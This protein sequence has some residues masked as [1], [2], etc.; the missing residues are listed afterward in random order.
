MYIKKTAPLDYARVD[1]R[2]RIASFCILFL[3]GIVAVRLFFLMIIEHD[4]YT[5]IA[6]GSH[7]STAE[8]LPDRGKI[9]IQDSR[10]GETYPA[11]INRDVFL[12]Y[13]DTREIKD[14]AAAEEIAAVFADVFHYDD[15]KKGTVFLQLG[16]RT[17]PYEPIE[18]DVNEATVDS[19]KMHQLS[20]IGFV[21][22]FE[23]FYPEETLAAQVVG[24]VGKTEDGSTVGRYGI[25]GYWEQ[26][27][28][29]SGGFLHGVKSGKGAWIPLAGRSFE[30]AKDG[31]DVVLTID[32]T[33]QFQ[34]CEMLRTAASL[35]EAESASLVIMDPF[36]GAIRAMCS[37]LDFDPNTYWDTPADGG[38]YNNRSMYVAYEQGSV[39][40]PLVMAA[41]INEGL[42][43]PTTPFFDSGVREG[44][45]EH[46]IRNAENKDY[47]HQTMTGILEKSINTGMVHVAELL[48]RERMSRY[49]ERLGFGVKTGIEADT[50][51]AGDISSIAKNKGN[52]FDCYGATAAFG[53][54]ITITPLQLATAFS[55]IANGGNLMKPR[56]VE[57]VR[58]AD[59]KIERMKE[60]VV[61]S[62]YT[63]RS[64]SLVSAMLVSAIDNGF[65]R[66]GRLEHYY[67][68]GKT[69]T[70]Q[71]PGP[72]GYT[73]DTYH[74]FVGF[75]PADDPKFVAV[76]VFEKPTVPFS[77]ATAAPTFKKIAEFVLNY[78]GIAPGR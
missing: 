12:V 45:C 51:A 71:I 62:V 31:A 32:R 38:A 25:E 3:L 54:G 6:A 76:I 60:R 27:L 36:T 46:P 33:I 24:F 58:Y 37:M 53:Q 14:D 44:I 17:D 26:T 23:R 59:G 4:F 42:V 52:A 56:L 20:G 8:L 41:A 21:R 28:A 5:A 50:E 7:E 66:G 19:I 78:Y 30:P 68:G 63:P 9:F 49:F 72:G 10:T 40:K 55:A 16:K 1:V 34:T 57:E 39:V 64:A 70:A 18:K 77:S 75:A 48:G 29:G 11:A 69:G 2:L 43:E 61:E 67:V 65:G 22:Q 73:N 35:Y 74:T 15:E 13:A 47:G